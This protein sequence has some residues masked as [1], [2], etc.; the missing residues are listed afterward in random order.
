M[1][2]RVVLAVTAVLVLSQAVTEARV[3]VE[4]RA[5]PAGLSPYPPVAERL[6]S[7]RFFVCSVVTVCQEAKVETGV[8]LPTVRAEP[9]V[10]E[11]RVAP[12]PKPER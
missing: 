2:C 9:A 6:A 3:V 10:T 4:V 5:E 12:V 1:D 7:S 11:A 8:I